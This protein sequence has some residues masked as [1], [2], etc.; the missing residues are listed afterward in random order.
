M[1]EFDF[2]KEVTVGSL[3]KDVRGVTDE[4]IGLNKALDETVNIRMQL[5]KTSK[6]ASN[7][8]ELKKQRKDTDNLNKAV[9][10]LTKT[11]KLELELDKDKEKAENK[12]KKLNSDKIQSIVQLQRLSKKQIQ[13]NRDE[14][15][16]N[17]KNAGTLEK[18]AAS[19]RK[20]RR[21]REAL[22]LQT[23]KGQKRLREINKE[24]DKNN[25]IVLK[26]ADSQKKAALATKG[27]GQSLKDAAG[28]SGLFGGV[29]GKLNAVT[30]TLTALTKK[31]VIAEEADVVAKEAQVAATAQL[32]FAQRTLN[33]AQLGGVKA[34]KALK[35]ALAA[36]GIGLV[37]VGLA[38]FAA[39][40]T[41]IQSGIDKVDQGTA[42]LT[43]TLDVLIDRLSS[44]AGGFTKLFKGLFTV[45]TAGIQILISAVQFLSGNFTQAGKSASSLLTQ[46]RDA[47]GNIVGGLN[48]IQK[49][50][51]GITKE[52][53]EETALA[54]KLR[55][56]FQQLTREQKLFEA[57]QAAGLTIAKEQQLISRDK[58]RSDQDRIAALRRANKIEVALAEK[59]VRLQERALA[60]A[61]D[62][63]SADEK[64]L[65]L[66][67]AQLS[68]IERI[69]DGTIG[70]AEAVELAAKFTL[71]SAAGESA[72]FDIV[73]KIKEQEQARQSLLDKRATTIKRL[74]A[75]QVIIATKESTASLQEAAVQREIFKD[76][77]EQ[78]EKRIE[79]IE[80]ARDLTVEA[81]QFRLTANIINEREFN[82][83]RLKLA[84]Q[85]EEQIQKLLEKTQ[86]SE[87]TDFDVI[88]Q[89]Q[90]QAVF[91]LQQEILQGE[92]EF[93]QRS[94]QN[95]ELA[96]AERLAI[97]DELIDKQKEKRQNQFE[98]E[99]EASGLLVSEQKLLAI[100]LSNDQKSLE[101]ERLKNHQETNK[102]ILADD[103]LLA[104]QRKDEQLKFINQ[105]SSEVNSLLAEQNSKSQQLLDDDIT[106]AR[107]S[108]DQQAQLA[109]DG[110]ENILAEEEANLAK[111]RLAKQRE[112]KRQAELAQAIALAEAFVNNFA[113]RSKTNPDT[114]FALAV[115]DTFVARAF[116]KG[117]VGVLSAY[118]GTED[119]G[120]G[121]DLDSK[122][123]F[124]AKIHPHERVMTAKQ[125]KRMGGL[126]NDAVADM[127]Y[128]A[129]TGQLG[130]K[131]HQFQELQGGN[132]I[133]SPAID[134]EP[135]IS[136]LNSN[137]VR[138]EGAL[139]RYQSINETHWNEHGEAVTKQIKEGIIK[140]ITFKNRRTL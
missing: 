75:L 98:F 112:L 40:L 14:E 104:Q 103:K 60:S 27:Y 25:K 13:I 124:I 29:L 114:A 126:S 12:L 110:Q 121:G 6:R 54:I 31:S 20:L 10:V 91:K 86:D 132:L 4:V 97:T 21:E 69:K 118:E 2:G 125:N 113:E 108:R 19:S 11:K 102:K 35:V 70:V 115:K 135:V 68:F 109:R 107:E 92:I 71:S 137:V 83:L 58:L 87:G 26:T 50:F 44:A 34:L 64:R 30:A 53:K 37:L 140:Y 138:I 17:A 105:V 43:A 95:E 96:A 122:G 15:I 78:L 62:S 24:L 51:E 61:L 73:E 28:A 136:T 85:T 106:R 100:Q 52:L 120:S 134:M 111:A 36:S 7:S 1:A 55:K 47:P 56:L 90:R 46:L 139:K 3:K 42:G 9:S 57:E 81:A 101:A 84:K 130:M 72:L 65:E 41:R 23:A 32:T 128:D 129:R 33:R 116:A 22:N 66:L 82:A 79:A 49:A 133:A 99:S 117:L 88:A 18:L 59:Q 80:L 39:F 8:K 38:S 74:S 131:P 16:L 123:G 119:T 63:I 77:D 45:V 76:E 48:E 89:R 127:I 93:L 5:V 67:P 94:L